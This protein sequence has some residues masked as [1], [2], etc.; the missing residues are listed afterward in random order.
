M[1]IIQVIVIQVTGGIAFKQVQEL[2]AE[3]LM[4]LC[5]GKIHIVLIIAKERP[6][7]LPTVNV[8]LQK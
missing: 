1:I 5:I 8:R 4:E 2:V 3:V 6:F 7:I